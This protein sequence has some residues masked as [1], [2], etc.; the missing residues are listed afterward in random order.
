ML[1]FRFLSIPPI[2]SISDEKITIS[3]SVVVRLITLFTM[4]RRVEVCS[5]TKTLTIKNR[6]F[7]FFT[8]QK[9]FLFDDI[10]CFEYGFEMV[11][12]MEFTSRRRYYSNDS[13]E[14][15]TIKAVMKDDSSHIL[16]KYY[17]EGSRVSEIFIDVPV[18]DF[19]GSQAEDSRMLIEALSTN[20]GIPVGKRVTKISDYKSLLVCAECGR[21]SKNTFARCQYCGGELC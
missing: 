13:F 8:S 4:L 11:E 2:V 15:F 16:A 10:K 7:Y 5:K 18:L 12:N 17:G 21:A 9:T 6:W 3:T 14:I 1:P 20:T 19:A